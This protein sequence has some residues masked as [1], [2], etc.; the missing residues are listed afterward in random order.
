[1]TFKNAKLVLFASL[2][3]MLALPFS[4]MD[5][6]EARSE[7]PDLIENQDRSMQQ[8]VKLLN[9]VKN[10]YVEHLPES[11]N[12]K[13]TLMAIERID[14]VL[15]IFSL[16]EESK[17]YD[18][19]EKFEEKM[20]KYLLNKLDRLTNDND[21]L[22]NTQESTVQTVA[23]KIVLAQLNHENRIS[24]Y[25]CELRQTITGTINSSITVYTV[26]NPRISVEYDLP[27]EWNKSLRERRTTSCNTY[28]FEQSVGK[29]Y[30]LADI[31]PTG[32]PIQPGVCTLVTADSDSSTST[33]C[34]HLSAGKLSAFI[35]TTT[36]E[37]DESSVGII[38]SPWI[39]VT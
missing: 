33:K 1:M 17:K 13:E 20:G 3:A 35:H 22:R 39:I 14:L 29:L 38:T 2:I 19:P 12:F 4:M 37:H 30:V 21:Y 34:K 25:D 18:D 36:Y 24:K 15:T 23:T 5:A 7:N 32:S 9:D 10:K 6:A 27:D 28:E 26:G 11:E 16:P 8:N 31:I